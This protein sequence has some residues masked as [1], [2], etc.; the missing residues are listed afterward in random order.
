MGFKMS[1]LCSST[2]CTHGR[3]LRA[4]RSRPRGKTPSVAFLPLCAVSR[5]SFCLRISARPDPMAAD[6]PASLKPI[7]AYL[8]QAKQ[9]AADPVIAYH[10]RLYALQEAMAM[11]ASIPKADMGFIL[12]LMDSLEKEK[13]AQLSDLVH[14]LTCREVEGAG[15]G[16]RGCDAESLNL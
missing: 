6:L 4:P 2:W 8:E 12:G 3:L 7:K 13:A 11:R 9:R 15:V 5:P 1:F 16:A 14:D 10:C